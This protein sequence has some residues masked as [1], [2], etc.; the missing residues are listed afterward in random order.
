MSGGSWPSSPCGT[1]SRSWS[2]PTRP[3]SSSPAWARGAAGPEPPG[4]LPADG[5]HQVLRVR[6]RDVRGLPG[7]VVVGEAVRQAVDRVLVP[8]LGVVVRRGSLVEV[9]GI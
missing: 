3:A 2:W 5:D 6:H 8:E 7:V 1:G 9:G 4:P